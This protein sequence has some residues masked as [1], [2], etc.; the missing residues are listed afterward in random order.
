MPASQSSSRRRRPVVRFGG[1]AAQAITPIRVNFNPACGRSLPGRVGSAYGKA[2]CAPH[3]DPRVRDSFERDGI[4]N[5]V[6]LWARW[7]QIWVRYGGSRVVHARSKR[8]TIRAIVADYEDLLPDL[9]EIS[10]EAAQELFEDPPIGLRA[11]H[12]ALQWVGDDLDLR[13][14]LYRSVVGG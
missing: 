3:W 11:E 8:M 5:P 13:T 10:I 4:W 14:P 12:I 6:F 9:P 1:V 2:E 7:G